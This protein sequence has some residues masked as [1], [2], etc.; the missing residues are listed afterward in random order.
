MFGMFNVTNTP[1]VLEIGARIVQALFLS[2][3][4]TSSSYRGQWQGGRIRAQKEKQ[5]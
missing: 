2:I 5:V 1:F 4:G 3:D